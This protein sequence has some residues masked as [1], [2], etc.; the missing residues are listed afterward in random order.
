MPNNKDNKIKPLPKI[1]S[2]EFLKKFLKRNAEMSIAFAR[3][4]EEYEFLKETKVDFVFYLKRQRL[5]KNSNGE[6]EGWAKQGS[7]AVVANSKKKLTLKDF[8]GLQ[9]WKTKKVK[10]LQVID[11]INNKYQ[12]RYFAIAENKKEFKK[13]K[14]SDCD[15]IYYQK[16]K[17]STTMRMERERGLARRNLLLNR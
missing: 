13:L 7:K 12:G 2:K 8:K 16:I 15:I 14:L 9:H 17:S 6:K 4:K 3:N 1:Y 5:Y 11:K 10:D